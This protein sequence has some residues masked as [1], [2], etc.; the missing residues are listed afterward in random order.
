[1]I[2]KLGLAKMLTAHFNRKLRCAL[3][4]QA[5][6]DAL[7]RI[8]AITDDRGTSPNMIIYNDPTINIYSFGS[9]ATI[10]FKDNKMI[11]KSSLD[12]RTYDAIC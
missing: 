6:E 8:N 2:Y 1:M 10:N 5:L 11:S 7:D 3:W 4:P 12:K 9:L